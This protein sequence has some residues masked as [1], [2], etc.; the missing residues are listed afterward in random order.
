MFKLFNS[1]K[2]EA[3]LQNFDPDKV[4]VHY[5]GG[6]ISPEYAAETLNRTKINNQNYPWHNLFPHS[7]GKIAYKLNDEIIEQYEGEFEAGQY[8]GAGTLV[9]ANGE[10][11]EG[12]FI[13]N[14]FIRK[15]D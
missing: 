4:T 3:N 7:H 10:I 15:K 11:H 12:E 9:D 2:N 6:V 1:K 13:E 5:E 14:Q 8:H